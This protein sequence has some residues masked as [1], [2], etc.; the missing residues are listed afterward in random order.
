M[1]LMDQPIGAHLTYALQ[2]ALGCVFAA[3]VVPKLRKP[4]GFYEVVLGYDI[5]SASI[6]QYVAVL[7]IATEVFLTFALLTGWALA[8]A[9][10]VSVA[11]I[12]VFGAG[13]AINLRRHRSIP[14]GCFGGSDEPISPRSL[15][16]LVLMLI[17]CLALMASVAAGFQAITV[18]V[19][20]REG[21][22]GLAYL[23]QIGALSTFL[24]IVT[25]WILHA[26]ELTLLMRT[27][28]PHEKS[29]TWKGEEVA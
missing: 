4:R 1:E 28:Y 6:A 25:I 2:L 14:C 8:S 20:A 13:V 5:V 21:F 19:L 16:R 15:I 7:I 9:L 29:Q 11:S 10:M 12:L 3:A 26:P 23:I 18:D 22:E 24:V 17:A 27:S